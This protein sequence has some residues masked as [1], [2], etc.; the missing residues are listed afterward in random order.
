MVGFVL[1]VGDVFDMFVVGG[2]GDF[3]D[4]CCFV[5]LIGDFVDDDGLVVFVNFFGVGFGVDDNVVVIF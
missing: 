2:F 3:F 1:N 5:D 4:Y